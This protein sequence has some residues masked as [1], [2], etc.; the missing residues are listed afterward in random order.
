M[1]K[2][3]LIIGSFLALIGIAFYLFNKP[4]RDVANSEIDKKIQ[5]ESL[6]QY[7]LDHP[8]KA[9]IEYLASDGESKI[10]LVSGKIVSISEDQL[11]QKVIMLDGNNRM[12]VSCSFTIKTNGQTS[13]LAKGQHVKIKGVIRSGAEYDED[14]DLAE[15]VI[16]E[17][18]SL[19]R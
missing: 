7:F 3:L 4:H 17:K 16:L 11:G 15:D 6:V 13:V 19:I 10:L 12:G 9:N 8:I 5:A 14:L 2:K 1:K 18:C